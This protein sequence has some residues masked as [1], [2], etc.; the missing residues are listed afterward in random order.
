VTPLTAAPWPNWTSELNRH[1]STVHSCGGGLSAWD[2]LNNFPTNGK[3]SPTGSPLSYSFGNTGAIGLECQS[4][5]GSCNGKTSEPK[6]S[7]QLISGLTSMFVSYQ[8]GLSCMSRQAAPCIQLPCSNNL[9]IFGSLTNSVFA[10]G[11]TI[12][13]FSDGQV[14]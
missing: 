2:E 1:R 11:S 9:Q 3:K 12:G 8:A 5:R 10:D 13:G 4:L 7:N 14:G 6:T